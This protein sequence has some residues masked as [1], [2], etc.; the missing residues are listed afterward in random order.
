MDA[1]YAK[2]KAG[3]KRRRLESLEDEGSALEQEQH[4]LAKAAVDFEKRLAALCAL[5]WNHFPEER[6][7]I[8]TALSERLESNGTISLQS[9]FHS[10]RCLDVYD[11]TSPELAVIS[12]SGNRHR[13]LKAQIRS[14]EDQ[15]RPQDKRKFRRCLEECSTNSK[16]S[17]MR[18]RR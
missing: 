12:P 18:W 15:E 13:V 5:V 4:K 1:E 17:A 2:R 6:G 14:G 3:F 7:N 10:A 11:Y 16:R 8:Q 9:L